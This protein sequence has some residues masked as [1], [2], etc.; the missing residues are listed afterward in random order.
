MNF[1]LHPLQVVNIFTEFSSGSTA[2]NTSSLCSP[3]PTFDAA[4]SSTL[5]IFPLSYHSPS[6]LTPANSSLDTSS[7][8]N[9]LLSSA[10]PALSVPDTSLPSNHKPAGTEVAAVVEAALNTLT[11]PKAGEEVVE[12][13]KDELE[14]GAAAP[15]TNGA[16]VEDPMGDLVEVVEEPP[17]M[18]T[19]QAIFP[20]LWLWCHWRLSR[21]LS[22]FLTII[23]LG[24]PPLPP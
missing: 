19:L 13:P 22:L 6:F 7:L 16:E 1:L 5:N 4:V 15:N 14:L 9:S 8:F 23:N 24:Q 3:S 17:K 10:T 18:R 12:A 21:P 2:P 20:L 11:A